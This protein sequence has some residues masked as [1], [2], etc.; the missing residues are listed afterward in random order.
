MPIPDAPEI[1]LGVYLKDPL[2]ILKD[3][4]FASVTVGTSSLDDV[5]PSVT[6]GTS[7]HDHDSSGDP[8]VVSTPLEFAGMLKKLFDSSTSEQNV[9]LPPAGSFP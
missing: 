4:V 6:V 1:V 5:F 2:E 9:P 8:V 3:G 7:S